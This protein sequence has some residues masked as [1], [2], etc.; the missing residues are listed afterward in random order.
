MTKTSFKEFWQELT[1]EVAAQGPEAVAA[2]EQMA[3]RYRLG[4]QL[5][6]ARARKKITQKQ[7]ADLTGI[8]QAE[9]SRIERGAVNATTDTLIRVGS[10]LG[11]QLEFVAK[12]KVA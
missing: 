2:F 7:L 5:S 9:I 10:H 3:H 8:D 4:G 1:D 12:R 11:L 6:V